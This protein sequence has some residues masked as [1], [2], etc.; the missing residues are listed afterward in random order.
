LTIIAKRFF[1]ETV[2]LYLAREVFTC[3]KQRGCG[4]L[5]QTW[6]RMVKAELIK[7][8]AEINEAT[9]P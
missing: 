9:L 3:N 6:Q 4:N 5:A 7:L 1:D 8:K 2:N